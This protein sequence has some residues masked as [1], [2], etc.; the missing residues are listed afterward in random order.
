MWCLCLIG[1]LLGDRRRTTGG[2][3]ALSEGSRRVQPLVQ[4]GSRGQEVPHGG[5]IPQRPRLPSLRCSDSAGW[6]PSLVVR[7]LSALVHRHNRNVARAHEGLTR[8]VADRFVVPRSDQDRNVR[9]ERSAPHR[10]QLR[11]V[12]PPHR[13]APGPHQRAEQDVASAHTVGASRRPMMWTSTSPL[14]ASWVNRFT[15]EPP[16]LSSCQRLRWLAPT[17]IW[18]IW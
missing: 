2:G 9:A 10:C 4:F 6:W 1:A 12:L 7:E 16:P 3:P 15:I 13:R 18:V 8:H 14:A 5:A 17:I 11:H